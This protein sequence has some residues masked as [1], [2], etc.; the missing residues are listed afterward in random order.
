LRGSTRIFK[1]T[2]SAVLLFFCGIYSKEIYPRSSVKSV[3]PNFLQVF[4]LW[5]VCA[6][7]LLRHGFARIN[8][9]FQK[10]GFGCA[11]VFLWHIQ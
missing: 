9:D 7:K 8:T 5:M 1:S 6:T 10:H 3:A 4:P 11:F 2:A